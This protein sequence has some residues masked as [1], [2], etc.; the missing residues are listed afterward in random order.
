MPPSIPVTP[1]VLTARASTINNSTPQAR[2]EAAVKYLNDLLVYRLKT[3]K[4]VKFS[5][6]RNCNCD[7]AKLLGVEANLNDVANIVCEIINLKFTQKNAYDT[8]VK[9]QRGRYKKGDYRNSEEDKYM[10]PEHPRPT[11]LEYPSQT[12]PVQE[13]SICF[14]FWANLMQIKNMKEWGKYQEEGDTTVTERE[15]PICECFLSDQQIHPGGGGVV[16]M[17]LSDL[18]QRDEEMEVLLQNIAESM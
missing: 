8:F 2:K 15:E 1:Y 14:G 16:S 18:T 13:Y 5:K 6:G 7:L 11:S 10:V 17:S 9:E 3:S 4:C 12:Y